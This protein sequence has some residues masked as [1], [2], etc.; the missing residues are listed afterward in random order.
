MSVNK[1]L[2]KDGHAKSFWALLTLCALFTV[3]FHRLGKSLQNL[4]VTSLLLRNCYFLISGPFRYLDAYGADKFV[5]RMHRLHEAIGGDRF[6]PCQMLLDY[7]K[8][9]SKK[10]HQ[11]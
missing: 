6:V 4:I 8:D 11:R 2:E 7:A 3:T 9:P 5:E 1:L 10:F